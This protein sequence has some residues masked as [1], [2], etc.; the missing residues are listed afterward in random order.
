MHTRI[1]SQGLRQTNDPGH[2]AGKSHRRRG[3][4]LI[5]GATS[6]SVWHQVNPRGH[7][8]VRSQSLAGQGY[9]R[10]SQRAGIEDTSP[11]GSPATNAAQILRAMCDRTSLSKAAD[12]LGISLRQ[13]QRLLQEARESWQKRWG[14]VAPARAPHAFGVLL[15]T[16]KPKPA[17]PES[18][19]PSPQIG[20]LFR[21]GSL[22]F[23]FSPHCCR[24]GSAG[25]KPQWKRG[26]REK[27]AGCAA[28]A[29][30]ARA[31]PPA[32]NL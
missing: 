27:N 17:S 6:P 10:S 9:F 20:K 22:V 11:V 1:C 26:W 8:R 31:T 23:P 28:S 24:R 13:A 25:A 19:A 7:P 12:Q 30:V 5:S 32:C 18:M 3:S 14:G 29:R 21:T 2:E 15:G 16:C 4:S